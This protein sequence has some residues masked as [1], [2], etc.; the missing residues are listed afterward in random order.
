MIEIPL[1]TVRLLGIDVPASG[2]GYFRLFPYKLSGWLVDRAGR[3]NHAPSIFYLH[4]WEIDPDQPR[5]HQAPPLSRFRHYLNLGRTEAR[6]RRLLRDFTWT[7]MDR[8][9]LDDASGPFPLVPAW[10]D[11]GSRR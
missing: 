5:Q 4:P 9:F 1:S 10:M 8:L 2:G 7:R 11:Q 6:L 3:V